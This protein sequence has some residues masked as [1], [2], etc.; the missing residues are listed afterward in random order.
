MEKSIVMIAMVAATMALAS[1]SWAQSSGTGGSDSSGASSGGGHHHH[2][3]AGARH[4][5]ANESS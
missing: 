3:K 1:A 2:K 4:K 5:R